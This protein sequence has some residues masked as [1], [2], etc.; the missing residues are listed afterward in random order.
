MNKRK[1]YVIYYKGLNTLHLYIDM[2][3]QKQIH[4]RIYNSLK[5]ILIAYQL[6]THVYIEQI[7]IACEHLLSHKHA[8][9]S[10]YLV[11][12]HVSSSYH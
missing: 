3:G 9:K 2:S 11:R 4:L 1:K 12:V 10:V 8:F 6:L 7:C 5:H